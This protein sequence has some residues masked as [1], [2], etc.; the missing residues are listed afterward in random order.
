LLS[1]R[2]RSRLPLLPPLNFPSSISH[3]LHFQSPQK[4]NIRK[5]VL[6]LSTNRMPVLIV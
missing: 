2:H 3:K 1:V 5:S 4:S 6:S